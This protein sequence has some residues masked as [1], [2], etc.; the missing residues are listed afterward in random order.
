MNVDGQDKPRHDYGKKDL[1]AL[2]PAV[3]VVI[4]ALNAAATLPATLAALEA[5][6]GVFD[7]DFVVADGG[8]GDA[9]VACAR[10]AGAQVIDA[11]RGRGPQLSAG[12]DNV[13]GDWLVFL[14]ADTVLEPG[15][16]DALAGFMAR[17]EASNQAAYFRFALDDS[18]P[19]ARRI[20]RW[21]ARRC[22]WFA[23]PYGDQGLV[24]SRGLY[25]KAGGFRPMPLMEDVD[26][27]RRIA[28]LRGRDALIGLDG[29]A[30][31]YAVR[32]RRGGY[33]R[34]PLR[35]MFCL[36]LYFLGV[37]PSAIMKIYR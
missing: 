15:W 16:A 13:S 25:G 32:Y 30:R 20:E 4:P 21:V 12:A 35:N 27:V 33:W 37:P 14:H 29:V 8:S 24:L 1:A 11:P 23:L 36:V 34:R 18:H 28:R 31:T 5:G 17:P 26:L 6:R 7:L 3:G 19:G 9:T 22:R 10:D 2:K